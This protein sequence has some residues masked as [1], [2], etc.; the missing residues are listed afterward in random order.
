[1]TE[2][3]QPAFSAMAGNFPDKEDEIMLSVNAL[4][5][6]GIQSPII[7]MPIDLEF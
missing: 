3:Y 6:L 1:M 5:K 2:S 7:G 4:K